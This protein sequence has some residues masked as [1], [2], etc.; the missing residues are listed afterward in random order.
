MTAPETFT[1]A[2]KQPLTKGRRPDM[3]GICAFQPKSG[4]DVKLPLQ[5]AAANVAGGI[6]SGRRPAR[7]GG[8]IPT[9]LSAHR[10]SSCRASFL[11]SG[12]APKRDLS[13]KKYDV[14]EDMMK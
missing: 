4:V 12:P 2:S 10:R 3:T 7:P 9:A 14:E 1:A 6:A 13:G 11:G 8:Q 5:T